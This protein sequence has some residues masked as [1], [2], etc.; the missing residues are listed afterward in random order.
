MMRARNAGSG[1]SRFPR[2][3]PFVF[4]S[5]LYLTERAEQLATGIPVVDHDLRFYAAVLGGGIRVVA[6]WPGY[7]EAM[8]FGGEEWRMELGLVNS[9]DGAGVGRGHFE[10]RRLKVYSEMCCK[11]HRPPG[12]FRCD[13]CR[14]IRKDEP[15]RGDGNKNR[16]FL[17]TYIQS[18]VF[19]TSR[20]KSLKSLRLERI[21]NCLPQ[22]P[23]PK[24][25]RPSN[26]FIFHFLAPPG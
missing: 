13:E 25:F 16:C 21:L 19:I 17:C 20:E 8:T 18:I 15:Y 6:A 7:Q 24:Q 9:V 26:Y 12:C 22:Q 1:P 2:T 11:G 10:L 5:G 4:V 23:V 3:A 14:A